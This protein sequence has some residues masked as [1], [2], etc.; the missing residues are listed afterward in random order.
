MQNPRTIG[1]LKASEHRGGSVKEEMRRNLIGKIQRREELFPGVVGYSE[2]VIPLIENSIL[3]GQ[4]LILLGERGQAK[5]RI[6]RSLVSLLD[7]EIPAIAGCEIN[8]DPY[9][10]ICAACREKVASLGD[11]TEIA[12]VPRDQRY[13]EKLATPNITIADLI[14]EMDPLR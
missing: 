4:D 13:S 11:E 1:E 9:H 14:G 5:T 2:T 12:W 10:P 6:A 3:S 8:D 7:E